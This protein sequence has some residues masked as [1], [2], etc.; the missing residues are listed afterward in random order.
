MSLKRSL[1]K[2]SGFPSSDETARLRRS[3]DGLTASQAYFGNVEE[4]MDGL[5]LAWHRGEDK[6]SIAEQ[7]RKDKKKRLRRERGEG[8]RPCSQMI[9][10]M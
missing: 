9:H 3:A 1:F 8:V 4:L 5:I 2:N 6:Q 7:Q 10:V